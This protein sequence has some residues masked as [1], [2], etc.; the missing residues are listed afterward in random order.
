MW[1]CAARSLKK[2]D[3]KRERARKLFAQGI[4]PRSELEAAETRAQTLS[5][6]E[7]AA[8][9]RL[10]AAL[11]EHRRKHTSAATEMNLAHSDLSAAALQIQRL[12]DELQAMR[13]LNATSKAAAICS[14]ANALSSS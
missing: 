14:S 10:E 2:P 8:R 6:E 3:A 12:G 4:V 1:I 9:E 13:T 11:T 5:I 7:A